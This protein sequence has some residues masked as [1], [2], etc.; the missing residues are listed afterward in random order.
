MNTAN[1]HPKSGGASCFDFGGVAVSVACDNHRFMSLAGQRYGAFATEAKPDWRIVYRLT[2]GE[3]PSPRF[4]QAARQQPLRAR[5]EG[6]L[7]RL[8]TPTFRLELDRASGA[9]ELSGPL[10]TYPV[11]RMIQ[12]LWYESRSRGL[13]LHGAA[14]AENGRGWLASGPSGSGKS[15]L[16]G[17]FPDKALCDE[18]AA[19]SLDRRG[20]RLS[21]MPFW[22]GRQ[23]SAPLES[24]YLLRHG[25]ADSRRRLSNREAFA[26][27][28]REVRWPTS[29]GEA[30]QRALDSLTEILGS[31]PI[32]E[33]SFRPTPE[34]WR[35]LSKEPGR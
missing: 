24:I 14:L 9:A 7:L 30:M 19:V 18:F 27:L 15:T 10:A 6:S 21:A 17:L 26:R 35:I 29:D 33:L 13:I 12:T 25:S 31:V 32:W 34:V 20:P 1:L 4:I 16:A 5:R 3:A 11:D 23:G 8:S 28:R 22:K 2:S